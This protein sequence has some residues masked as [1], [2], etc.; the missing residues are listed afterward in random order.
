M[1]IKMCKRDQIRENDEELLLIQLIYVLFGYQ[2]TAIHH[3][4]ISTAT[5]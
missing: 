2:A 5:G 4:Y 1:T 3:I